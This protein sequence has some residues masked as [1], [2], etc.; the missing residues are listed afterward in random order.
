MGLWIISEKATNLSKF[1][2]LLFSFLFHYWTNS[3]TALIFI[4]KSLAPFLVE[5]ATQLFTSPSRLNSSCLFTA[6]PKVKNNVYFYIWDCIPRFQPFF[7][8]SVYLVFSYSTHYGLALTES[9]NAWLN[10]TEGKNLQYHLCATQVSLLY[11]IYDI[12]TSYT[13]MYTLYLCCPI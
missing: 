5:N 1:F 6:V 4:V 7:T 10:F 9:S 11:N 3:C 12:W 2:F 8:S 13:H